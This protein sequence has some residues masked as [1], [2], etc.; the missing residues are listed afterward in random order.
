MVLSK[1]LQRGALWVLLYVAITLSPL[2]LVLVGPQPEGRDFWT[3]LSVAL[4]F[5][6][7]AM[8]GLQFVV[9][10]KFKKVAAPFGLDILLQFHRQ[11]SIIALI[12]ILLHPIL[13]FVTRPET[14]ALLNVFEAPWRA[15][16]GLLSLL[17][18]VAIACTSL[19]RRA[20]KLTYEHWRLIHGIFASGVILFALLH[21]LLVGHYLGNFWKQVLWSLMG[22]AVILMLLYVRIYKPWKMARYPYKVAYVKP[23]RGN[24]WALGL[25]SDGKHQPFKFRPG[26]F[27]W[28]TLG[29]SPF[30]LR[31]HPF[32]FS[33]SAEDRSKVEFTIKELGDFTSS[34]KDVQ[35]GTRAYLDGPRGVFTIDR[36]ASEH[37]VF[38][39][40]GI[41]ISPIMSMLRTLADRGHPGES[42][43]IYANRN[44]E[45]ITYREE[46]EELEG[47]M[48]LSV[49][50]VLGEAPE[51]D[52]TGETGYITAEVLQ[53]V[54]PE[55]R[56][57][58][59]CFLCGP[60]VM[61]DAVQAALLQVGVP[62]THIH[63]EHFNLID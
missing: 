41:G 28:I 10:A 14:L 27:A 18:L 54:L 52:W 38:I 1:H 20:F 29:Q 32:S 62:L 45:S 43:L 15:R 36:F 51:E 3:E 26:Q 44:W 8:L 56:A 50:H 47:R 13:L 34:L 17:L 2:L 63:V 46:I 40:G 59:Q 55:K 19:W 33:S 31:E 39:A 12:L 30:R 58:R 24:A 42:L 21:V 5:V 57:E 16:F 35:P 49:L 60:P 23:Q 11:I 7:L 37:Y 48:N 9:T 53:R 6:G 4:G 22:M 25:V 61:M